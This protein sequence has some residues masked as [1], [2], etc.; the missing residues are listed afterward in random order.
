[1]ASLG[2]KVKSSSGKPKASR[3]ELKEQKLMDNA[4]FSDPLE[5]QKQQHALNNMPKSFSKKQLEEMD[6]ESSFEHELNT[7]FS[8]STSSVKS[9][10]A[11][12][13]ASSLFG[14][15]A[16]SKL[17]GFVAREKSVAGIV[18]P[19][20][21]S[22]IFS[23]REINDITRVKIKEDN[24]VIKEREEDD[25]LDLLSR[26]EP[27]DEI[28]KKKF[29]QA[30][31]KTQSLYSSGLESAAPEMEKI[32][33]FE[34]D[35]NEEIV[36]QDEQE[37]EEEEIKHDSSDPH[38]FERM[39]DLNVLKKH[40]VKLRKL[41][42]ES[43]SN[44]EPVER[45]FYS[46]EFPNT[47]HYNILMSIFARQKVFDR[48]EKLFQEIPHK[49]TSSFNIMLEVY[50][51]QGRYDEIHSMFKYIPKPD[52]ESWNILMEMFEK[53]GEMEKAKEIFKI[54]DEPSIENYNTLMGIYLRAKR[55]NTVKAVYATAREMHVLSKTT[56]EI[57]VNT[58]IQTKEYT[59]LD[60]VIAEVNKKYKESTVFSPSTLSSIQFLR[61]SNLIRSIK[62]KYV[63]KESYQH[64]RTM[65]QYLLSKDYPSME[66][67]LS[68]IPKEH[69]DRCHFACLIKAYATSG[70]IAKSKQY[71]E[72]LADFEKSNP[73]NV[74]QTISPLDY[75][76]Y[77]MAFLNNAEMT[78]TPPRVTR[79]NQIF[80]CID[81]PVTVNYNTLMLGY[82]RKKMFSNVE[83]LFSK[84][85]RPENKP[86]AMTH[87][88]MI[89]CYADQNAIG[90]MLEYFDQVIEKY[91]DGK[92]CSRKLYVSIMNVCAFKGLHEKVQQLFDRF[93]QTFAVHG[94]PATPGI[95]EW[96]CLLL[97]YSF[98]KNTEKVEEIFKLIPNPNAITHKCHKM[99]YRPSKQMHVKRAEIETK[100]DQEVANTPRIKLH[101]PLD[102]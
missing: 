41:A 12:K 65:E 47:F 24:E 4:I 70:N 89:R 18:K 22:R 67:A 97:A 101:T 43:G 59:L 34:E 72:A 77:L 10:K 32:V 102:G 11:K 75:N 23:D 37:E 40:S 94:T 91:K 52:E 53:K 51:E 66:E 31:S 79:M 78:K 29:K 6:S 42:E 92:D 8:G 14:G 83:A 60:E 62:L 93:P 90:K 99:A 87:A 57:I 61:D 19:K 17:T 48:V 63:A 84:M 64:L 100:I 68:Q 16:L 30:Q 33:N 56:Y 25:L 21:P 74:K 44:L 50:L 7:T 73:K 27:A 86:N 55:Y 46:I 82:L 54:I 45:Y 28:V 3:R 2:K 71:F 20:E 58:Y 9:L 96:N 5:V 39:F 76:Q 98:V 15:G 85:I 95:D 13:Q 26:R 69:L 88:I 1:M 80:N 49:N 36:K 81:K 38:I 35:L